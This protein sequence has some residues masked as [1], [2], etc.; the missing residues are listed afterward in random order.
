MHIELRR[1]APNN[2]RQ[3]LSVHHKVRMPLSWLKRV[4]LATQQHQAQE[5][6]FYKSIWNNTNK[7]DNK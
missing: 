7:G 6:E 2:S 5:Q 1:T 3:V 4:W